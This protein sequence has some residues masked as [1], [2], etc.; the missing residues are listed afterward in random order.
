MW[1]H[2]VVLG[3]LI[4]WLV[5]TSSAFAGANQKIIGKG[6]DANLNTA[7]A[8]AIDAW[9]D[10]AMLQRC[11]II[12][13][14]DAASISISCN[15]TGSEFQCSAVGYTYCD[16]VYRS[17]EGFGH[18][19]TSWKAEQ[20][21][22]NHWNSVAQQKGCLTTNWYNSIGRHIFCEDLGFK[23]ICETYGTS[24]CP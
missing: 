10:Q 1:Y 22:I 24:L 19:R 14:W 20:R 17:I 5:G 13:W 6:S 16:Y 8:N 15:D 12:S 11:D 18:E 21:A 2:K 3:F 9:D 4:C 23:F 7:Q